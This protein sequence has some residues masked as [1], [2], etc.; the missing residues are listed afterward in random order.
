MAKIMSGEELPSMPGTSFLQG[1]N[2]KNVL[3]EREKIFVEMLNTIA[4]HPLASQSAYFT[5][6]LK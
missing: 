5:A 2:D 3:H 4:L 6:F 1:R